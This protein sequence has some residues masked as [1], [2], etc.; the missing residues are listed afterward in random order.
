MSIEHF[1][2]LVIFV[3]VFA[4]AAIYVLAKLILASYFRE[5][6]KFINELDHFKED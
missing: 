3:I 4:G 5:K 1:I 6:N 2:I